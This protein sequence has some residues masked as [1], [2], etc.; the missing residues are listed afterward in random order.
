MNCEDHD[1][2]LGGKFR[3]LVYNNIIHNKLYFSCYNVFMASVI[4]SAKV[5]VSNNYLI[6]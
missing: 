6:L 1:D 4:Q 5:T 3:K 2:W